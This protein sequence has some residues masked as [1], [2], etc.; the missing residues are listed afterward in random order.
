MPE[1]R[2]QVLTPLGHAIVDTPPLADGFQPAPVPDSFTMSAPLGKY[3]PSNWKNKTVIPDTLLPANQP[4]NIRQT[5][6]IKKKLQQYQ[7]VMVEQAAAAAHM[8]IPG[9]KPI[10][11][12]LLPL[13][14]PGPV[15]PMELEERD[16]YLIAG[17]RSASRT[18]N[19]QEMIEAMVKA[20]MEKDKAAHN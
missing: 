20:E 4:Q 18:A 16:G 17:A 3:H 9:G 1:S 2:S 6:D 19:K 15:T 10:S 13:L 5:S 7:R 11:P 12:R 8:S 14:S